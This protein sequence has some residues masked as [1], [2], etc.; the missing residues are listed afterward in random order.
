MCRTRTRS[1][2]ITTRRVYRYN[3]YIESSYSIRL[4]S[5]EGYTPNAGMYMRSE[6]PLKGYCAKAY[7][8]GNFPPISGRER[9]ENKG[10]TITLSGD[11]VLRW[12]S[13]TIV[14]EDRRPL[15]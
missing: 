3:Y 14:I 7:K 15:V 4:F 1:G 10:V 13:T 5:R 12:R 6:G 2:S 11:L 9:I 8:L